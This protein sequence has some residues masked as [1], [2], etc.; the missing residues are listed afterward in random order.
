MT[1]APY[2]N[3]TRFLIGLTAV[4]LGPLISVALIENP[5]APLRE[6]LAKS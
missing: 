4:L 1:L 6:L 3:Q 2:A 5:N